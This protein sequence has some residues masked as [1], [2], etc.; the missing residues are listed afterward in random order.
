MFAKHKSFLSVLLINNKSNY[1]I[2][3][4]MTNN[5]LINLFIMAR[6]QFIDAISVSVLIF[7]NN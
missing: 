5:L 7:S 4:I 1:H 3:F 2:L 6:R